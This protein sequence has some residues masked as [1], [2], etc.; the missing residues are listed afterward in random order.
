MYQLLLKLDGNTCMHILLYNIHYTVF[1]K[2]YTNDIY[3]KQKILSKLCYL[4]SYNY[5]EQY[6]N[7]R[8][9]HMAIHPTFQ[10]DL[11][12]LN[13]TKFVDAAIYSQ[14][15]YIKDVNLLFT[16]E[17]WLSCEYHIYHVYTYL[18]CQ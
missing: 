5:I 8:F 13:K 2:I 3:S 10:K 4:Q 6:N 16:E 17:G 15:L 1:I 9:S 7:N 11:C 14:F 18:S 12:S